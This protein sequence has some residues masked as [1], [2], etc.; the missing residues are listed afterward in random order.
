MTFFTTA[1]LV[2][3]KNNKQNVREVGD[4]KRKLMSTL[5]HSAGF[6]VTGHLIMGPLAL[7]HEG[8]LAT[9]KMDF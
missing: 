4:C 9:D 7:G 2:P 5:G 6:S 8:W 3:L 1:R